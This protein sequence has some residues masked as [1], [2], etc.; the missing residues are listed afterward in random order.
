MYNKD[1]IVLIG[2]PGA[3]K[4]SLTDLLLKSG[5]DS[6]EILTVSD[7]LKKEI[8]AQTKH[9]KTIKLYM[10]DGRLVP[11]SI[12]ISILLNAI[13]NTE[14][15]V[16]LDGFPRTIEQARAMLYTGLVPNLVVEFLAN[17]EIIIERTKN[18]IV[19]SKCSTPYSL[20]G[21]KKRKIDGICDKCQG[22]LI[23]RKDDEKILERL[24]EYYK[25]TFPVVEYLANEN[26]K[27]FSFENNKAED[28]EK[29][30]ELLIC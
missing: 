17:D 24:R 3:G 25:I 13:K 11:D 20:K 10:D 23:K 15:K 19:C 5:N 21:I 2:P 22:K 30:K 4:G 8:E 16:I 7:L 29:V 18:R 28:L 6:I 9:G 14:K 12:V 26:I 27:I 1:I